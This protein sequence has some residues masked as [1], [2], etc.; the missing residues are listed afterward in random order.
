MFDGITTLTYFIKCLEHTVAY[1]YT[2]IYMTLHSIL[3]KF[4]FYEMPH[5][6]SSLS[7]PLF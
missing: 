1:I 5:S 7:M 6:Y 2:Y 4:P 3:D